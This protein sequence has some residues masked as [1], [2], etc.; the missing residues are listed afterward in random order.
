MIRGHSDACRK[1]ITE[2]M[3]QDGDVGD[4]DEAEKRKMRFIER[5]VEQSDRDA[6]RLKR[7]ADPPDTGGAAS[8]SNAAAA[9]A[10][11]TSGTK[12]RG[13][14]VRQDDGAEKL[15]KT[16]EQIVKK[17][18]RDPGDDLE[19]QDRTGQFRALAVEEQKIAE[20]KPRVQ[21]KMFTQEWRTI[22][23]QNPESQ[24]NGTCKTRSI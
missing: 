12:R 13:E 24:E 22:L 17:R 5:E 15:S 3:K 2:A 14:E 1:R 16:S 4:M 11:E 9:A 6:K 23:L 7:E 8:S 18:E 21:K 19:E 10:P 20:K